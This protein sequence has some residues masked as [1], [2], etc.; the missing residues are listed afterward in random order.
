MT[1][2]PNKWI[3]YVLIGRL[4]AKIQMS[5]YHMFPLHLNSTMEKCFHGL[6]K[7]SLGNGIFTL[8]ILILVGLKYY[9]HQAWCMDCLVLKSQNMYVR[10]ALLAS[11]KE[12]LFPSGRSW[13]APKPLELVHTD[14]CG[15][16]DPVSI[17]GN[18]YFISF[19]DDFN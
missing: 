1:Y 11:N 13:R 18:K 12:V 15:P 2:V 3:T 4:V 8:G 19:I 16:F 9:L 10:Y 7:M 17:G 14:I 5:H 6:V